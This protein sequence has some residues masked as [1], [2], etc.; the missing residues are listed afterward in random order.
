[1]FKK[2]RKNRKSKKNILKRILRKAFFLFLFL[3]LL[4]LSAERILHSDYVQMHFVYMWPYQNIILEYSEK[5]DIDPFLV[6]AVM[7]NE[8]RFNPGAVSP[9]GAVGLMQIMPE[10]GRWI[11]HEMGLKHYNDEKLYA[12][13][14]NIRM[15]CWYLSELRQE[16][17]GNMIL[18]MIAYNAG[19]GNT[20]K[21]MQKNG[22]SYDFGNIEAIPYSDTRSY[23]EAVMRD[24]EVYY[25]LYRNITA[26]KKAKAINT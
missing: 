19:R 4:S 17:K 5:N 2:K 21:W 25:R 12:P 7:K 11:A 8:S 15:G 13:E 22:W 16:F 24:R 9:V 3:F 18:I 1:M 20:K 6:A 23:V 10:T 26:A 14:T